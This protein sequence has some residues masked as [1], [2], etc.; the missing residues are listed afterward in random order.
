MLYVFLAS[1]IEIR[2]KAASCRGKISRRVDRCLW[3]A[4]DTAANANTATA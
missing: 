2:C 1:Q 4:A 3:P